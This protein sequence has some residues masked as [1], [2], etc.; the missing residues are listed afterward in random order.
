[1]MYKVSPIALAAVVSVLALSGIAFAEETI[2]LSAETPRPAGIVPTPA[3][4]NIK[5]IQ[6]NMEEKRA[7]LK[8]AAKDVRS[9][10][11]VE[12]KD[13]RTE[14]REKMSAEGGSASGGREATSALERREIE[15]SA[16]EQRKGLIE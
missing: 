6:A 10:F 7:E 5:T 9:N 15:K 3:R 1:M 12:V 2:Q 14:T 11:K 4:N 8:D 16:I 13:V